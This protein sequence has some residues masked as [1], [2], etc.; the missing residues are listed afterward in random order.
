MWFLNGHEIE[1]LF[2]FDALLRVDFILHGHLA[3]Y[4]AHGSCRGHIP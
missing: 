2:D 4:M 1:H 3:V